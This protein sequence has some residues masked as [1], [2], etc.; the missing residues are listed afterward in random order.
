MTIYPS[1]SPTQSIR[2]NAVTQFAKFKRMGAEYMVIDR[3]HRRQIRR[4]NGVKSHKGQNELE[5]GEWCQVST[6]DSTFASAGLEE[7]SGS[8]CMI[9]QGQNTQGL[10]RMSD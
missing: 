7:P 10:K 9:R 4:R 3:A 6:M 8:S 2:S 1:V 5:E